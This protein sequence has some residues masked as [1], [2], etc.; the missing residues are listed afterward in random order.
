MATATIT[1]DL[2]DMLGVDFDPRRTKVWTTTNIPDDTII[3]TADGLEQ[4]RLG[5]GNV[6][7]NTDGT[8]SFTTW[9][10]SATT[11]PASWQTTIH[12]SYPDRNADRGRGLKSFGPFTITVSANLAD[13]VQ[14]AET[15]PEI[16][17]GDAWLATIDADGS[18]QYRQQQD[19]RLSATYAGVGTT[20]ATGKVAGSVIGW[21]GDSHTVGAG[22][23]NV[24]FA[25]RMVTPVY[26][27][28][29]VASMFGSVNGGIAGETS[30][31]VA[32]RAQSVLD[33]GAET[34]FVMCGTNDAGASITATTYIA[35]LDTIKSAADRA[36]VPMVVGTVPPRAASGAATDLTNAY[37]LQLRVWARNNGVPL[38][39]TWAA[40]VDPATGLMLAAY[41]SG[42]GVHFNDGG[43]EAM[44]ETIAP[45]LATLIPAPEWPVRSAGVGMFSDPLQTSLTPWA[46]GRWDTLS[47]YYPELAVAR[48]DNDGTLPAGYWTRFSHNNTSGSTR[49]TTFRLMLPDADWDPGD[50]I[51]VFLYAR[52]SAVGVLNKVILANA[53]TSATVVV[54]LDTPNTATPGPV[55][56]KWTIPATGAP[57]NL[58]L[59]VIISA[60]TG[61]TSWVEVGACDV[62]NLTQ[63]GVDLP[64]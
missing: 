29:L 31:Q 16:V 21:L 13:L 56:F 8:G 22:A 59:G 4:I 7:V 61:G 6:T 38:A 63:L 60:P 24:A 43:H 30:A 28:G 53:D 33:A 2:A 26:T 1:F 42:D 12:V 17:G 49:V 5:S 35:N 62:F 54:G 46:A 51:A 3:D 19:A 55:A 45:V 57:T 48:Q 47:G 20:R 36:G 23:S 11:N 50:E 10:P 41:D 27:G 40:L 58:A 37:N 15:P 34:L 44:A 9:V 25:F 64:I 32:A 18:S 14:Q 39:D 52:S